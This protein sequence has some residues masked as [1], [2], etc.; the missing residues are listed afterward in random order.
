MYDPKMNPLAQWALT[1]SFIF[2]FSIQFYLTVCG[3]F[4]WPFASHRLF[5]QLPPQKKPI[6]Q[7]VVTDSDGNVLIVHPGKVIPIEYSRCSGLVRN[8]TE[9]QKK[10][11]HAYVLKRLNEKPWLAFDE[12]YSSV[13]S[14]TNAPFV[15][16]QFETHVVD[17]PNLHIHQRIKLFP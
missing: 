7:V 11:L 16:L 12:M 9:A 14:P 15:S 6:V 2:F 1:A 17:F 3:G 10:F 4:C 5:S 13:K 8:I